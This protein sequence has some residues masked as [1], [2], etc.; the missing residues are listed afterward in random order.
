M[1]K[2]ILLMRPQFGLVTVTS[3]LAGTFA[4]RFLDGVFHPWKFL[5]TL[6]AALLLHLANN[7]INDVDDF[8][9][10]NDQA[11][12]K[13]V[14][15][16]SGGS[17]VILEGLVSVRQG[18]ILAYS[19]ASVGAL[20]GLYLNAITP[21]NLVLWIG[22]LGFFLV[23]AYTNLGVRLGYRGVGELMIFL[24]WG[25]MVVGAYGVQTGTLRPEILW[26]AVPTGILT[27][28][29]LVI[30]EFADREADAAVG[31]RTWAVL[32]GERTTLVLYLISALTAFAVLVLGVALG[33]LPKTALLALIALPLPL[34]AYRHGARTLGQMPAF[35]KS[36]QFTI[37]TQVLAVGLLA[38]G[39]L[40]A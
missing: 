33:H 38:V 10:G 30:N 26:V 13:A 36:V 16:F 19:L 14:R 34:E 12:T 2:Y 29:V 31:R 35:L 24:A 22:L 40:L 15:P 6:V 27:M 28:L 20:L 5:L 23:F 39:F 3:V 11:N 21:G 8:L 1:K 37:L 25:L 4:A 17:G 32:F 9:S 18:R 7:V